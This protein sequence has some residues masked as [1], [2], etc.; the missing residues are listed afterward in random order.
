MKLE[1]L[2][3]SNEH[4]AWWGPGHRGYVTKR[5]EAGRYTYDTALQIVAGANAHLPDDAEPY[6]AMVKCT[7]QELGEASD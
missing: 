6:E 5:S 2:I 1:W 7:P 3:W 4:G